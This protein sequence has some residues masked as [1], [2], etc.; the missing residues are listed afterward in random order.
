MMRMSTM[1]QDGRMARQNQIQKEAAHL[2][3]YIVRNEEEQRGTKRSCCI[4]WKV[5]NIKTLMQ[6]KQQ[7]QP[8]MMMRVTY[9]QRHHHHHRR[10]LHTEPKNRHQGPEPQGKNVNIFH[11]RTKQPTNQV[12]IIKPGRQANQRK[13]GC[14]LAGRGMKGKRIQHKMWMDGW[15]SGC[16]PACLATRLTA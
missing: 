9:T 7:Q 10:T 12:C 2:Y 3:L 11:E 6:H 5:Y 16:L 14:W 4:R 15:I 1:G 13:V 8:M